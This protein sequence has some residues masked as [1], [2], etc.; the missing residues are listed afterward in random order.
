[1]ATVVS[2][3]IFSL[4]S[5]QTL[6]SGVEPE[7]EAQFG[8]RLELTK[9]DDRFIFE[10]PDE[11]ETQALRVFGYNLNEMD[12]FPVGARIA[13]HIFIAAPMKIASETYDKNFCEKDAI[14]HTNMLFILADDVQVFKQVKRLRIKAMVRT[15]ACAR[16]TFKRL[17]LKQYLKDG[18]VDMTDRDK[19]LQFG[20]FSP[21]PR[22]ILR[23]S[24]IEGIECY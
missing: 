19:D 23:L 10:E 9:D 2:V 3:F 11:E 20:S 12:R 6:F 1:M 17:R 5:F 13:T 8:R 16:V 21:N 4:L 14:A 24:N 22:E 7:L 18:K 15:R